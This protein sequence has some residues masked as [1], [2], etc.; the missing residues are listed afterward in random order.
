MYV[1][2]SLEDLGTLSFQRTREFNGEQ[3]VINVYDNPNMLQLTFA[4]FELNSST[5]Q[6]LKISYH[7]FENLFHKKGT[8]PGLDKGERSASQLNW[9]CGLLDVVGGERDERRLVLATASPQTD[10]AHTAVATGKSPRKPS[11]TACIKY[12]RVPR[13]SDEELNRKREENIAQKSARA[14]ELSMLELEEKKCVAQLNAEARKERIADASIEHQMEK[15]ARQLREADR[16][17]TARQIEEK[18][19][20]QIAE[21]DKIRVVRECEGSMLFK[22]DWQEKADRRTGQLSEVKQR[23]AEEKERIRIEMLAKQKEWQRLEMKREANCRLRQERI[24]SKENDYNM[25]VIERKQAAEVHG[26]EKTQRLSAIRYEQGLER[27]KILHERR[28]SEVE[29]ERL[30]LARH[31]RERSREK[32]RARLITEQNRFSSSKQVT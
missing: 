12:C 2:K 15:E 18:R 30:E 17:W 23:A 31:E 1:S 3:C 6:H 11:S 22:M 24:Q 25:L 7:E 5:M 20:A 28:K 13:P 9:A 27:V 16:R 8:D 19:A 29:W 10:D 32:E 14:N 26:V 21:K 4:L